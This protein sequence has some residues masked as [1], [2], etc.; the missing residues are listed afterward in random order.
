MIIFL[1]L[2]FEILVF[3]PVSHLDSSLK[4][5]KARGAQAEPTLD[6]RVAAA[7]GQTVWLGIA[8]HPLAKDSLSWM[9]CKRRQWGS[10]RSAFCGALGPSG[11]GLPGGWACNEKLLPP[12]GPGLQSSLK[13]EAGNLCPRHQQVP[14]LWKPTTASAFQTLGLQKPAR[15]PHLCLSYFSKGDVTLPRCSLLGPYWQVHKLRSESWSSTMSNLH[16]L[17]F[18]CNP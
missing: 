3:F 10:T 12:T 8:G 17:E 11:G 9:N 4:R 6:F 18:T 7:H 2:Q 1:S 13:P 16:K 15:Q 5:T 14:V